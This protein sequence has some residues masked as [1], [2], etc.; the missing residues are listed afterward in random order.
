LPDLSVI[1]SAASLD[2]EAERKAMLGRF[3][4]VLL[5]GLTHLRLP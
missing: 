5:I 3:S 4:A 2:Q 1:S